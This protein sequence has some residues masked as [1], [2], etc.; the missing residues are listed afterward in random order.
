M[1]RP[2]AGLLLMLALVPHLGS[3]LAPGELGLGL[4]FLPASGLRSGRSDASR[5]EL[6]RL[7]GGKRTPTYW[8]MRPE[9]ADEIPEDG[10]VGGQYTMGEV[11]SKGGGKYYGKS[12]AKACVHA[13]AC[14]HFCCAD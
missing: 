11:C 12:V 5:Q 6:L 7:R 14:V 1:A 4:R 2:A 3:A 10:S 8:P 9:D 13:S